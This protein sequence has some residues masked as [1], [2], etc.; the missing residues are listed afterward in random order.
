MLH[1]KKDLFSLDASMHYINCGYMGPLLK[2]V[3]EAGIMG[4]QKKKKPLPGISSR[5]F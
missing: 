1:C 4:M 3:E 5:F 2:S